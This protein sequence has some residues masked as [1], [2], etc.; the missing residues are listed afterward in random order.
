MNEQIIIGLIGLVVLLIFFALRFWIGAALGIV[1][2]VGLLVLVGQS[3]ALS[4]LGSAPFANLNQYTLTVIPM[5][6]LMGMIIAETDIGPS[7][8]RSAYS[9]V[10]HFRGGLASATVVACGMLGAI[11]GGHYAATTIM[12]RIALPEMRKFDY[13][14]SLASG[15]I[16]AAAPLAMIIPP[17]IALVMFGILTENSIGKLLMSGVIPG[18][19]QVILYMFIIYVLC[20]RNPAL[21]PRWQEIYH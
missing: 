6:T 20:K 2:F 9:L 4:I 11:T 21:G 17:S 5:F 16:A 18:V 19:L 10:G 12:A 3:K 13:D 8:Y 14:E 1:G 15:S 7:L